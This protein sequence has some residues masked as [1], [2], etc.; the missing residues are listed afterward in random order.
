MAVER[1]GRSSFFGDHRT[2]GELG[3]IRRTEP[4][5]RLLAY[6]SPSRVGGLWA[7]GNALNAQAAKA[8]I[9]A[10]MEIVP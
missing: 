2:A 5:I 1:S 10:V 6:G 7:Y 9:E 8:F 4:S 3:R